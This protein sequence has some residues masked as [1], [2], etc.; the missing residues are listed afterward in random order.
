MSE[1][2]INL[3][4]TDLRRF[5]FQSGRVS[6]RHEDD[7]GFGDEVLF[8][9]QPGMMVRIVDLQSVTAGHEKLSMPG[10]KLLLVCK[11]LGDS[12][13][14]AETMPTTPLN[15]GELSVFYNPETLEFVEYSE[16]ADRYL[17]VMLMCDPDVFV[18]EP[19]ELSVDQLP[20][21]IERAVAGNGTVA[22]AFSM[23][24]D[25][26]KALYILLEG[27]DD[28]V[29][30][31]PFL[32]AKTMEIACLI[33]RNILGE[34]S[35]RKR[36]HITEKE[37]GIVAKAADLLSSEWREPPALSELVKLLGLGKSRLTSSFKTIYGCTM[38]DYVLNLRMQHAQQL[39]S[40]G[41]LNITQVAMEVG[42]EH[43]SNFTSAFKRHTGMTPKNFQK[44]S[45]NQMLFKS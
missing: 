17:L 20:S 6:I 32:Q 11:L 37:I 23:S 41:K 39:L 25:L 14:S 24:N 9:F 38:S 18:Q 12:L 3:P 1:D 26:I 19:F 28:P 15:E 7:G 43:A 13:I 34:E 42:Y 35:R 21:C 33:M 36:A 27:L 10:E 8:Q 22:E 31:R 44:N 5:N 2:Y 29:W 30:S 16:A 45:L 4:Y 40:E